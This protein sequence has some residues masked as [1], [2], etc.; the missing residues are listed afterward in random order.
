MIYLP[1]VQLSHNMVP[2]AFDVISGTDHKEQ[3]AGLLVIT[4]P[5][6]FDEKIQMIL[7]R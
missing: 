6:F 3:A 2:Q 4:V 1:E 5:H 7:K